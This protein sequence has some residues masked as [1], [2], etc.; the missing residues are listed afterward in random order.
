MLLPT[1]TRLGWT[2]KPFHSKARA[3]HSGVGSADECSQF[4]HRVRKPLAK[5]LVNV[6]PLVAHLPRPC[7]SRRNANDWRAPARIATIAA[8]LENAAWSNTPRR[9]ESAPEGRGTGREY[10]R[11]DD[12]LPSDE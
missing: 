5:G 8:P 9:Q 7:I 1:V 12:I 4:C 10:G 6:L 11:F 2:G 3:R